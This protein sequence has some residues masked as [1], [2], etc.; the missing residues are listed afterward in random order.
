MKLWPIN[1]VAAGCRA[2]VLRH[3]AHFFFFFLRISFSAKLS[4][5]SDAHLVS[6]KEARQVAPRTLMAIGRQHHSVILAQSQRIKNNWCVKVCGC[7]FSVCV[8]V[9]NKTH[10]PTNARSAVVWECSD[11]T[12][13]ACSSLPPLSASPSPSVTA[14]SQLPTSAREGI[15]AP[16]HTSGPS[17]PRPSSAIPGLPD[18]LRHSEQPGPSLTEFETCFRRTQPTRHSQI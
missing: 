5:Q 17:I 16:L 14:P 15:Q 9:V 11:S 18:L 13:A 8:N 4:T 6:S 1:A 10:L 7:V 2:R 12:S 3:T